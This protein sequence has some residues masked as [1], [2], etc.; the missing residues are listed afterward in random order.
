M[1]FRIRRV[2]TFVIPRFF[3]LILR[4][5][6]VRHS[7]STLRKLQNEEEKETY[8]VPEE[9]NLSEST[10]EESPFNC[11]LYDDNVSDIASLGN[12]TSDYAGNLTDSLSIDEDNGEIGTSSNS[13]NN[14]GRK[15][16]RESSGRK[17]SAGAIVGIVIGSVAV[18][19]L[20]LGLTLYLKGKTA[21]AAPIQG[22]LSDTQ[23]NFQ[24]NNSVNV[25]VNQ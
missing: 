4:I 21:S 11:F 1:F 8:C 5:R 19:A 2:R 9:D 13:G 24:I 7:I 12:I 16:F 14:N 20:I 10:S 22:D 23:K 3:Y 25:P 15:Y 18:V 6:I 17:L